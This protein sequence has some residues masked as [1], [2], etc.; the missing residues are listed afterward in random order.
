MTARKVDP[1]LSMAGGKGTRQRIW[2]AIRARRYGFT[3]LDIAVAAGLELPTTRK[4]LE[5]LLKAGF[6][7]GPPPRP[8]QTKTYTLLRDNGLEAP[9]LTRDGKPLPPTAQ[10]LMWRT[11]RIL[12]EFDCHELVSHATTPE[13]AVALTAAQDYLKHLHHAGYVT[14][15]AKAGPQRLS[16]YRLLPSKYTG[17]RPPQVLRSKVL[18]DPN[19]D[20]VV[21]H[22]E[23][24]HDDL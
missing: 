9:R 13:L 17:P 15:V 2:E 7:G 19:L 3:R 6:I 24:N 23:V 8:G 20:A 4:Y 5:S 14:V 1:A 16:R 18:F 12:R 11:L 22:E 21:W 10:E